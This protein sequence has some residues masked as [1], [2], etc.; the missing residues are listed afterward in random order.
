MWKPAI[1]LLVLLAAGA[2]LLGQPGP[3]KPQP[4]AEPPADPTKPAPPEKGSMA[5]ELAQALKVH[6]DIRVAEAKLRAA[7]A[8][9]RVAEA[10]LGRVRL[11]VMQRIAA[12]RAALKSAEK[13]RDEA[14]ERYKTQQRLYRDKG[15]S[16]EDLRAAELTWYKYQQEVA[17]L[18]AQTPAL[19]GTAPPGAPPAAEEV[20]QHEQ[21]RLEAFMRLMLQAKEQ[22]AAL[23][24][25]VG[26]KLRKALDTP[27][28][29]NYDKVQLSEILDHLQDRVPGLVIR[30]VMDRYKDGNPEIT[31][32]FKDPLPLRA[33]LQALEDEVPGGGV[34]CVVREYGLLV[35]PPNNMPPGALLLH[36]FLRG[37]AADKFDPFAPRAAKN[38][39]AENVEGVITK[40]DSATGLVVISVGSDAGLQKG[41]TLEVFRLK[42]KPKYVGTLRLVE[43]KPTESVGK[44][45]GKPLEP[46]QVGDQ[47][48]S[49]LLGN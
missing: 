33:V 38:P 42:P 24:V 27:V 23:P 47:V 49:K 8:E 3:T 25:S 19:L 37:E 28:P 21:A 36:D 44:M 48:A 15:A 30:S 43:A 46:V 32:R 45:E 2:L 26:E 5:E 11:Q 4:P 12:H 9:L 16:F 34:R 1:S 40:V 18:Q 14:M 39:P 13:T 22:P 29:V 20:R 41:H 17:A 35:T 6:P 7:E 10:E 31:L